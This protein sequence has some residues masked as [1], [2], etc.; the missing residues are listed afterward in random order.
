MRDQLQ[1]WA[2]AF[3][4]A[5]VV[6]VLGLWGLQST[7][8][9]L[10]E[11]VTLD[12]VTQGP[13]SRWEG[14]AQHVPYYLWMSLW[15]SPWSQVPDWWLRLPS[16]ALLALGALFVA[17]TAGRLA[18]SRAGLAAGLFFAVMPGVGRYAQEARSPAVLVFFAALATWLLVVALDKARG[19]RPW[20]IYGLVLVPMGLMQ[21]VS[22][23]L[24]AGHAVLVFS[25]VRGLRGAAPWLVA[26]LG[27]V[28]GVLFGVYN[29][30][31]VSAISFIPAPQVRDAAAQVLAVPISTSWFDTTSLAIGAALVA[32]SLTDRMGARWLVAYAV[33]VV[34]VWAASFGPT[35]LW[36]GR[37]LLPLSPLLA[38]AAGV[39]V[40]R[41]PWTQ[42]ALLTAMLVLL[43]APLWVDSR[44]A[45]GKDPT[46]GPDYRAAGQILQDNAR[47]GDSF[48]GEGR[49]EDYFNGLGV[50]RYLPAGV[51][52]PAVSANGHRVWS[53]NH[54]DSCAQQQQWEIPSGTLRLCIE[55]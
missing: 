23:A 38:I 10:D 44:T 31:W 54:P 29:T 4:P 34:A 40:K 53:I 41:V 33:P 25:A 26:C 7:T 9:W 51:E 46:F 13:F 48:L 36:L 3:V 24:L 43:A 14:D 35:S 15:S 12:A 55:P 39:S 19:A 42:L 5:M 47:P 37:Y 1:K 16:T 27:A 30:R 17:L 52:I 22:L 6:L 32:V 50:T 8:L 20:V 49:W 11:L 18:G 2:Y 21:P 28:P 45:G